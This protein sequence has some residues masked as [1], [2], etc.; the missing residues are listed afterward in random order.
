LKFLDRLSGG[1]KEERLGI[2]E[3]TGRTMEH[4][5]MNKEGSERQFS[6]LWLKEQPWCATLLKVSNDTGLKGIESF[7]KDFLQL[8]VSYGRQGRHEMTDI[9][10]HKLNAL[11][12]IKLKMQQDEL[13]KAKLGG[14]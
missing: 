8:R 14:D 11:E 3:A 4:F 12:E 2:E 9:I 7:V 1:K 13:L 5:R 10:K 6:Q